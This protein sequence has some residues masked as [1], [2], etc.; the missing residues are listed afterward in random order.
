MQP[1]PMYQFITADWESSIN[2]VH[3][4]QIGFGVLCAVPPPRYSIPT[5]LFIGFFCAYFLCFVSLAI[6]GGDSCK[7]GGSATIVAGRLSGSDECVSSDG[8]KNSKNTHSARCRWV[9]TIALNKVNKICSTNRG[10]SR[11]FFYFIYFI[12]AKGSWVLNGTTD[13]CY[14]PGLNCELRSFLPGG[15]ARSMDLTRKTLACNR[16]G[17]MLW[18]W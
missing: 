8:D 3:W 2:S 18:R 12:A 6:H 7:V 15:E 9:R 5:L 4:S 16:L 11:Y 10:V 13:N 14:E 17:R 1:A